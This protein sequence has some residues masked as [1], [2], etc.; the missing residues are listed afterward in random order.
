MITFDEAIRLYL[1]RNCSTIGQRV[2]FV[3]QA[4]GMS[5][6]ELADKTGLTRVT[7]GS[8]E[9]GRSEPT[10]KTFLILSK[11]LGIEEQGL[12]PPTEEG[13]CRTNH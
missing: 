4:L 8:I 1:H 9:R 11:T 13:S 10:I 3:R 5:Q 7:I 12:I 6:Q 2:K